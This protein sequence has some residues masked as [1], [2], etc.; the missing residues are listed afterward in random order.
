[1][2][3]NIAA[4]GGDPTRVALGG[5]SA[6]AVDTGANQLSP[7]AAGLFNRAIYQSSP[8]FFS[9]LP[10]ASV[11]LTNG[12]NFAAA[13]GCSDAACLRKLSAERVLQLQGTPN[14]NGPYV[15][16]A[17]VDGTIIPM[18][19]KFRASSVANNE[20]L[21]DPQEPPSGGFFVT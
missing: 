21:V 11:A 16:D 4:F 10:S 3:A 5:Q 8:G 13:A 19:R 7:L 1:M 12:N 6:G 17:F 14:A 2:Q 18:Q 20:G 9:S 15:T